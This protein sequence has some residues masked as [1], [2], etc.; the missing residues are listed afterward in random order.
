MYEVDYPRSGVFVHFWS[1]HKFE[2]PGCQVEVS[3]VISISKNLFIWKYPNG[4]PWWMDSWISIR[5]F[6][7]YG[8]FG[9]DTSTREVGNSLPPR[10]IADRLPLSAGGAHSPSNPKIEGYVNP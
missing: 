3:M 9:M 4:H 6:L 7:G 10:E 1:F 8:F 5:V 2:S